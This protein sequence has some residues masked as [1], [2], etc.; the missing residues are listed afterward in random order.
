MAAQI[1]AGASYR[2]VARQYGMAVSAVH[3]HVR[4]YRTGAIP[5]PPPDTTA[6][7]ITQ[8]RDGDT[9]TLDSRASDSIRTLDQ[10]LDAC[11]VDRALW[12]VERWVA[13]KWEVGT[14]LPGGQVAVTP[15]WQVKAWLRP[16]QAIIDARAIVDGLL[17]DLAAAAP[18]RK[19]IVRAK[20][21][22]GLLLEFGL[23]D[24]HLALLS[25][26]EET[27][28]DYDSDIAEWLALYAVE[29]VRERAAGYG[30]SRIVVP[31]GHDWLHVDTEIDGR[32]GTTAKGT[33]QD[34]DSRWPKMF[35]RACSV[36][37][38]L[39]GGLSEV[40]PVEAVIVPGNHDRTRA[41]TLGE[42]LAAHYRSDPE[43]SIANT[44]SLRSYIEH[45]TVMLGLGH[46]DDIKESD[47]PLVMAQEAPEMW[48]RTT[49]REFHRGHTH[50]LRVQ[51]YA[52]AR[53]IAGVI[54][55]TVP[56][57]VAPDAWHASKG[58]R[59]ARCAEAF[60]W[61]PVDALVGTIVVS[62]PA[63]FRGEVAA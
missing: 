62:V 49:W 37:I 24:H 31:I 10:L 33:P 44:A 53:D 29:R 34:T 51:R 36:A 48:G 12:T 9:L 41:F 18:V 52:P 39:I 28:A 26:A 2:Q 4:R 6:R 22:D 3:G 21:D 27:G 5:E 63:E 8:E 16:L 54:V 58:Y 42:V 35:R 30:V 38:R 19:R 1:A 50:G 59:H 25:W 23:Y 7:Q 46:G 17:A 20:I 45:G 14:K 32:A 57:M 60:L 56:S 13:N 11:E 43:V 40:A 55:R 47:L 61:H 15:L